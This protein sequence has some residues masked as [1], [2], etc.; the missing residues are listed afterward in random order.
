M[1]EIITKVPTGT[2]KKIHESMAFI[3]DFFVERRKKSLGEQIVRGDYGYSISGIVSHVEPFEDIFVATKV[4]DGYVD[5]VNSGETKTAQW[6]EEKFIQ[7]VREELGE[8]VTFDFTNNKF[9]FDIELN[10]ENE[11]SVHRIINFVKLMHG[12]R[13]KDSAV[14]SVVTL[15]N[16]SYKQISVSATKNPETGKVEFESGAGYTAD[17]DL[18]LANKS[19]AWHE[20]A[21]YLRA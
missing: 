18:I 4:L 17:S 1:R 12:Y 3:N 7:R 19:G 13:F 5:A 8:P 6:F 21:G 15:R 20:L 9:Y 14:S 16:A 2:V 11:E 10:P